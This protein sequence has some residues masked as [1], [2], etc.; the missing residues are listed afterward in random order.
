[1]ALLMWLFGKTYRGLIKY[2]DE[3]ISNVQIPTPRSDMVVM[4]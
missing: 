3:R 1:M 4:S 2:H